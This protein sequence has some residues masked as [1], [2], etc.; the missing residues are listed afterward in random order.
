M[1]LA[2]FLFRS[3]VSYFTLKILPDVTLFILT[4]LALGEMLRGSPVKDK[5]EPVESPSLLR[6]KRFYFSFRSDRLS[7]RAV[8]AALSVCAIYAHA[9]L[10]WRRTCTLLLLPALEGGEDVFKGLDTL[11]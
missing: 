3:L 6:T 4:G 10:Y 7:L 5:Q 11:S 1:L 9:P 2:R 8:C